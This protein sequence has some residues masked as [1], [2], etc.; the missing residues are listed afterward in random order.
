VTAKGHPRATFQRAIEHGN[1]A[2]AETVLRELGRP[3]L[4]ELL[5]L[6]I[7]IAF[8]NPHRQPRVAARWLYRYLQARDEATIDEASFV[9]CC[10]HALAGP[11]HEHAATAL[12]DLAE[13]AS[14]GRRAA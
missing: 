6:T 5:E 11:S 2:V 14:S 8:K 4:G 1:L 10:L 9:V 12:R 13:K 3:S 7:L